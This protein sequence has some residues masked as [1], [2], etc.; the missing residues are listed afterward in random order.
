MET[1]EVTIM[2]GSYEEAVQ[3]AMS[4]NWKNGQRPNKE[5]SARSIGMLL[6]TAPDFGFDAKAV[7]KWLVEYGVPRSTAQRHT[8]ELR[9]RMIEKRDD[10]IIQQDR[11]GVSQVK[12][13][14]AVGCSRDT[15]QNV[16]AACRNCSLSENGT[17][18]D[19]QSLPWS[20]DGDGAFF[21]E[22]E[23][24]KTEQFRN[25]TR[26]LALRFPS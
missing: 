15:V 18:S 22:E 13:A 10:E 17:P 26:Q 16:L 3:Y 7:V 19:S 25:W 11:V 2:K 14:K 6:D 20:T 12:I 4:A 9:E 5:D 8:K 21:S 23:C 24:P 1:L